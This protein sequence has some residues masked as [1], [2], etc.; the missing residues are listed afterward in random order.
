RRCSDLSSV[1]AAPPTQAGTWLQNAAGWLKTT[2]SSSSSPSA[3]KAPFWKTLV[4][5]PTWVRKNSRACS[6]KSSLS[7]SAGA[8]PP[9]PFPRLGKESSCQLPIGLKSRFSVWGELS[10]PPIQLSLFTDNNSPIKISCHDE[11]ESCCG[12]HS[13]SPPC[14][15]RRPLSGCSHPPPAR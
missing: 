14:P 15:R 11:L 7:G 5:F 2:A 3:P 1:T 12:Q 10:Q 8:W 4:R 6:S 13:W 9:Y